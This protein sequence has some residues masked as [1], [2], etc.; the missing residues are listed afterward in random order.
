MLKRLVNECRFTLSITTKG[1]FIIREGRLNKRDKDTKEEEDKHK[2]VPDNIPIRRVWRGTKDDFKLEQPYYLPGT[3]LRGVMR[4]HLERIVRSSVPDRTLCCD[5]LRKEALPDQGCGFWLDNHK[6]QGT[7]HAYKRSCVVCRLFGSTAQ[8]SRIRIADSGTVNVP[9]EK[10]NMRD[11]IGIDR[12]TGGVCSGANFRDLVMEEG[13]AFQNTVSIRNFELWQLGL[14]AFV[15]RDLYCWED[16]LIRMGY[17]KSKGYG[18]VQGEVGDIF[19]SYFGGT[20]VATPRRLTD[21]GDT[22]S[23]EEQ[24]IYDLKPGRS[25]MSLED[26]TGRELYRTTWKVREN[27]AFWE[28]AA[29]A[30]LDH[31]NDFTSLPD[32]RG[33]PKEGAEK[34]PAADSS[35]NAEETP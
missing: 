10:M 24:E 7:G 2:G 15:I 27:K 33:T 20:D 13:V 30:W 19:I 32:L 18:Q 22:L 26:R 11:H 31:R 5:P 6:E 9:A 3:S 21:L 23:P 12:F 34:P 14:L 25:Q 28:T 8:G 4:S 1:P 29:Q 16:G 17:G 35:D